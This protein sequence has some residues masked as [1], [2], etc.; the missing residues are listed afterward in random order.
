MSEAR[1]SISQIKGHKDFVW[2]VEGLAIRKS[3]DNLIFVYA[4]FRCPYDCKV[5]KVC[6]KIP[7]VLFSSAITNSDA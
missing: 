5:Q 1:V 3:A 6:A 4:S 7:R 2:N